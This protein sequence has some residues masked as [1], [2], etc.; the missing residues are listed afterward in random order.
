[1]NFRGVVLRPLRLRAPAQVELFLVWRRDHENPLLPSLI[2]IAGGLA[3]A[4]T[5]RED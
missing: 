2:E 5:K 1:L 3:P 4:H